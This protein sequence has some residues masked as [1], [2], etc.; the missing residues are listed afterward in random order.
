MS[1]VEELDREGL[2]SEL[3]A[4][5]SQFSQASREAVDV[6]LALGAGGCTDFLEGLR[7]MVAGFDSCSF[8][9]ELPISR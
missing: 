7:M 4:V 2:G 3:R 9:K 1:D 8:Q 6:R 5:A